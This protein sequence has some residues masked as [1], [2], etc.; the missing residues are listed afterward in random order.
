MSCWRWISRLGA[1]RDLYDVAALVSADGDFAA[2]VEEARAAGKEVINFVFAIK[3]SFHL[4]ACCNQ[5]QTL[6]RKH[7]TH[8]DC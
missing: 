2:A 8:V 4:A 3:R 7:F 1:E 5:V 6:K